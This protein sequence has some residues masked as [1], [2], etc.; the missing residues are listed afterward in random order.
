VI[1]GHIMESSKKQVLKMIEQND[2]NMDHAF[3]KE[4]GQSKT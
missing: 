4:E 1:G 3:F 2:A